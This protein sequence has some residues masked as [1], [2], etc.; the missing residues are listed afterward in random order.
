[1]SRKW[2]HTMSI[3]QLIKVLTAAVDTQAHSESINAVL[4][5]TPSTLL[6]GL[7]D[8]DLTKIPFVFLYSPL[9][10]VAQKICNF[11]YCWYEYALQ[12]CNDILTVVILD[13]CVLVYGAEEGSCFTHVRLSPCWIRT[14]HRLSI[15]F[16][17]ARISQVSDT[18]R[19]HKLISQGDAIYTGSLHHT[20]THRWGSG[21]ACHI[22]LCRVWF[23]KQRD[24]DV[25]AALEASDTSL[26]LKS[27]RKV[28]IFTALKP[29]LYLNIP[30]EDVQI[31]QSGHSKSENIIEINNISQW[32]IYRSTRWTLFDC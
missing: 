10:Y 28:C 21:E 8:S 9:S 19:H 13:M 30:S 22:Q 11:W 4:G 1:M 3:T 31:A 7:I 23:S 20:A 6:A 15:G 12:S 17:A 14:N 16:L 32:E 2:N 5:S 29:S 25:F 27:K 18:R 24:R 26:M